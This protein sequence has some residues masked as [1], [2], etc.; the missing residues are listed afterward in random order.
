MNEFRIGRWRK[1]IDEPQENLLERRLTK[2][3]VPPATVP[4]QLTATEQ[5]R[6]AGKVAEIKNR[7]EEIDTQL[8]QLQRGLAAIKNR[9]W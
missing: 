9:P 6:V 1:C 7:L 3:S 2:K 4:R 5:K 8:E